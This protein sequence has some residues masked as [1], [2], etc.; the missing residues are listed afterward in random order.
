MN[1]RLLKNWFLIGLIG[2]S[3][4]SVSLA[5]KVCVVCFESKVNHSNSSTHTG[6]ECEKGHTICKDCLTLQVHC[7]RSAVDLDQLK[8]Q[9]LPCCAKEGCEK[10]VSLEQISSILDHK[11]QEILED[12]LKE[13]KI[14]EESKKLQEQRSQTEFEKLEDGVKDAFNICCPR[15]KCG[16]NFGEYPVEGC[17]AATCPRC[18]GYFCYLCLN[19]QK[20]SQ[21]AHDHT[22]QHRPG[23]KDRYK[24]LLARNK[25]DLLFSQELGTEAKEVLSSHEQMLRERKMWPMPAGL[26]TQSWINEVHQSGLSQ[27]MQIEIFQ[28]EYIFLH[29]KASESLELLETT[30][31]NMNAPVLTSLDRNDDMPVDNELDAF[32]LH[33]VNNQPPSMEQEISPQN[34]WEG[35]K[36][37]GARSLRRKV[38]PQLGERNWIDPNENDW[39]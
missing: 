7:A 9:G 35:N 34:F 22:F 12:R 13:Q 29:H 11:E 2:V 15:E 4:S 6:H 20:D 27:E 39:L 10:Y 8:N 25:L 32:P 17:T 28:N 24:W 1:I 37:R 18:G 3:F 14:K 5:G 36:K 21:A 19:S 30:L 31:L 16:E 33:P 38:Q 23:Y 26:S